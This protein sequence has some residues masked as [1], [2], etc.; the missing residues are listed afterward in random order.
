MRVLITGGVGYIGSRLAASW[1]RVDLEWFGNPG[2]NSTKC[3]YRDLTAE[4]IRPYDVV[5]HL[6]G[7]SRQVCDLN[8]YDA[9]RN[10]V[11]GFMGLLELCRGKRLIYASSSSVYN[12]IKDADEGACIQEPSD[13]YSAAKYTNDLLVSKSGCEN[14]YALRFGTVCGWSPN[15]RTDL[16]INSMTRDARERG[17]IRVSNP[18]AR[19]SILSTDD[20]VRAMDHFVYGNG[21]HGIYNLASFNATIG[22]IADGVGAICGVPVIAVRGN[23]TY[24]FS[25]RT[26][27]FCKEFE[28][29][30]HGTV[31]SIV[32]SL[33][34]RA[35]VNSGGRP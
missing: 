29:E 13:L 23:P 18:N 2:C 7:S 16:I 5:I 15:L 6:A 30:F 32:E 8:P 10:N 3:D 4:D 14:C 21:P 28:F 35:S 31:R 33:I 24:D 12:G 11:A 26:G 9:L 34:S 25:M 1:D 17:E 19:R 27:K 22:D 20:L